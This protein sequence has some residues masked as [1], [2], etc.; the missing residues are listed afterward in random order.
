MLG[1][2]ALAVFLKTVGGIWNLPILDPIS[3][4][5]VALNVLI[6]GSLGI[7]IAQYK[8][9]SLEGE[10]ATDGEG[11]RSLL[12]NRL[13]LFGFIA[14]IFYEIAEISINSLFINY[15]ERV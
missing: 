7:S 5:V 8:T 12:H 2:P 14:L 13:F 10:E 1:L 9:D 6:A 11:Y 3:D 4:T 15:A